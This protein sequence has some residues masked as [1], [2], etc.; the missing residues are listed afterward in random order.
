MTAAPAIKIN[1][2]ES[3][4]SSMIE[5]ATVMIQ[6][7][8]TASFNAVNT[9]SDKCSR[10]EVAHQGPCKMPE[11]NADLM[12]HD[13]CSD[14]DQQQGPTAVFFHS[15]CSPPF[16]F[17]QTFFW[18]FC[19]CIYNRILR[20]FLKQTEG[21]FFRPGLKSSRS[22]DLR[23]RTAEFPIIKTPFIK[24]S[25]SGKVSHEVIAM[26]P[27]Y[28][29]IVRFCVLL[30]VMALS[31]P[32][33]VSAQPKGQV[34]VFNVAKEQ[35]VLTMHNSEELQQQARSWLSCVTGMV[36]QVSVEPKRGLVIRIPLDPPVAASLPLVREKIQD[37]FLFIESP[38][39]VDPKLLVFTV[40]NKPALLQLKVDLQPF[41]QKIQ[42]QPS[43][44]EKIRQISGP[45]DQRA[46]VTRST[47]ACPESF[48]SHFPLS[49]IALCR[50]MSC[51]LQVDSCEFCR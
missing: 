45:R 46:L 31:F 18:M 25:H 15:P 36:P 23:L 21:G 10:K 12:K 32:L 38:E 22:S 20:I 11:M 44:L 27:M 8:K 4:F 48:H 29:N 5:P 13:Q 49:E 1:N 37:V 3:L 19:L 43:F 51:P 50:P 33:T 2:Q 24:G 16:L 39:A 6:P 30:L 40:D 41:I 9:E 34:Q 14:S 7:K 35:V 17:I 26:K 28:T 42:T 47:Q